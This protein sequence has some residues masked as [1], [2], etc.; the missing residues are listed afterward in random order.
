MSSLRKFRRERQ[1]AAALSMVRAELLRQYVERFGAQPVSMVDSRTRLNRAA[2]A[3]KA[4]LPVALSIGRALFP[5]LL[6]LLRRG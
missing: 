6:R 4:F 3:L 2:D 5:T 1:R